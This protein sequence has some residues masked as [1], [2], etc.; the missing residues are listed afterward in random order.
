MVGTAQYSAAAVVG[1]GVLASR[2]P[3]S[4]GDRW[5]DKLQRPRRRRRRRGGRPAGAR[6]RHDRPAGRR[7]PRRS[8][9]RR[10]CKRSSIPTR[11]PPSCGRP[12]ADRRRAPCGRRRPS[13]GASRG[14]SSTANCSPR[15]FAYGAH[16]E[17][18]RR[19]GRSEIALEVLFATSA[20][21]RRGHHLRVARHRGGTAISPAR[22]AHRPTAPS[23]RRS[24]E[25][26]RRT[27]AGAGGGGGHADRRR[28]AVDRAAHPARG[29]PG[30]ERVPPPPR[31]RASAW[32]S[33]RV[34]RR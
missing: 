10:D 22:R 3:D 12:P 34:A 13:A 4:G 24:P 11:S 1:R 17:I 25:S 19:D 32:P 14:A 29:L 20:R 9:P 8:A 18:S 16:V 31:R 2:E 5:G 28:A 26:R 7:D 27:A 33:R 6:P 21:A 30:I 15:S 23:S